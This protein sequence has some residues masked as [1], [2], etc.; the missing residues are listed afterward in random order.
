LDPESRNKIPELIAQLHEE[1]ALTTIIVTHDIRKMLR[2]CCR[3]IVM[4]NGRILTDES[5]EK[6]LI[7]LQNSPDTLLMGAN[8]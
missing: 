1:K 5:P 4:N 8:Q 2:Q 3:V 6:A 7:T